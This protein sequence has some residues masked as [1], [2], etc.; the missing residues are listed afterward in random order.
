MFV[1]RRL[2]VAAFVV[3][4]CCAVPLEAQVTPTQ[5]TAPQSNAPQVTEEVRDG[6]KYQVTR[7]VMQQTVP[8][9]VMQDRQQTVMTQ[10]VTTET[11]AHQQVYS[12]P[13]TQYEMVGTLHGRWNPFV[14]PYWTYEMQPVTYYQEQVANV[15]I[16]MNKVTWVPQ[17]KTV[18]VPVTEFRTAEQ[19]I[20]TRVA[21]TGGESAKTYAAAQP[22]LP[23][24]ATIQ[25]YNSQPYSPPVNS[26]ASQP[27]SGYPVQAT[28]LPTYAPTQP[29]YGYGQPPY[30]S[31]PT[32][33]ATR[34]NN[35]STM[36]GQMLQTDPPR[37]GSGWSNI[38]NNS[39]YR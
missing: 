20:T 11:I 2:T 14:E 35:Q 22:T 15:Q 13:V 16:P 39:G 8:T 23:Q 1:R 3:G 4:C 17:T 12:V 18:Q 38:P 21:L 29:S 9:T 5:T 25:P 7:Q 28:P 6:I 26:I 37:Q 36:G 30:N 10:Q 31:V 24:P 33:V 34:P 32:A 27:A 19:E